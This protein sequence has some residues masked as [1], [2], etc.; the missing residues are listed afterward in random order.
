MT[1]DLDTDPYPAPDHEEPPAGSSPFRARLTLMLTAAIPVAVAAT[2]L[3]GAIGRLDTA[4]FFVG[5]P[6]LLAVVVGVMP[7]DDSG[8]QLFQVITVTLLLVSAFLH[9]GALCVLIVSPLVYGLAFGIWALVKAARSI[10]HRMA[11][12]GVVL[13][14]ALEGALPG[15]RINP[16]QEVSAERVVADDC[17]QFAEGLERGPAFDQEDRGWLLRLAQYPTPQ[18]AEGTGLAVGDTWELAMP[19][20]GISTVVRARADDTILFDVTADDAR[21]TR[22]VTLQEGR[23]SWEQT[24]AGCRAEVAITFE[25]D[26][27][28]AFWFG[29]VSDLFM[30]A[31]ADA[32]LAGLD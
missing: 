15:T 17:A 25:R 20:G 18:S 24:D 26:L 13:L 16:V 11:L 7:S 14:A 3:A 9:E 28:P 21:T 27:D 31:G 4:L 32:F 5:V 30:T 8:A 19:M 29:P 12:G 6:V 23:L 2:L 10:G 22:W 1:R